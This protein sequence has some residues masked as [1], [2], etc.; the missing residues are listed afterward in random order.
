MAYLDQFHHRF[1]GPETGRKW[2]FLHGLMG[3]LN[4]WRTIIAGIEQTERCLVFDQ[5]GHG[6]S[7]KPAGGY[8]PENYADDLKTILDELGWDRIVLVGHSMGARNGLNFCTRFPERVEAFVLEDIGPDPRPGNSDYYVRML[9]TVPVPFKDSATARAF[10]QNDFPRL[11]KTRDRVEMIA[12]FLSANLETKPDGTVNWRFSPEAILASAKTGEDDRWHEVR[13]LK[14]P[15][16]LIHGENSRELSSETVREMTAANP[17]IQSVTFAGAGH[18]VHA[19]Q[20]ERFISEIRRFA[21]LP[22][23]S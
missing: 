17:M 19:D 8:A 22:V 20:P 7:L 5:R 9:G 15:T 11:F 10:F 23:S 6:R 1:Y 3:F 4:N 12:A 21:G 14:V 2:V 16:L 18:W 13:A